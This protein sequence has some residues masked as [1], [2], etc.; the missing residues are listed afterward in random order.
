M[1]RVGVLLAL[2]FHSAGGTLPQCRRHRSAFAPRLTRLS[3]LFVPAPSFLR[4][5]RTR[6]RRLGVLLAEHAGRRL[7][8][9][10]AHLNE[11]LV[12]AGEGFF[13][14]PVQCTAGHLLCLHVPPSLLTAAP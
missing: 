7:L 6:G 4:P 8:A 14:V 13:Q 11:E 2:G 1:F 10:L 9:R 12:Y 5:G 3:C